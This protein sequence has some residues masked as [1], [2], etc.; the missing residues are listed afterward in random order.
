MQKNTRRKRIELNIESA[1]EYIQ[2][3]LYKVKNIES[4]HDS[5]ENG[6]R[7]KSN[8]LERIN[9]SGAYTNKREITSRFSLKTGAYV[10]VP[11][12][13]DEDVEGSFLIRIFTEKPLSQKYI[14]F[15]YLLKNL[16]FGHMHK[17]YSRIQ[18]FGS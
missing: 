7:L 5:V 14:I 6:T 1:E 11:S 9:S 8:E 17:F 3:R 4:F 15:I 12:C 10:I 18:K 2:F 16:V 13:Y